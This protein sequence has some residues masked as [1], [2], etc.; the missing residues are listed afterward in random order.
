MRSLFLHFFGF[1]F[2]YSDDF[3]A[4]AIR[5]STDVRLLG[6]AVRSSG[7]FRE[8]VCC[9]QLG[10]DSAGRKDGGRSEI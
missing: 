4:Y 9:P 1:Y 5:P 3:N 7:A 8:E 2:S 6:G 10:E